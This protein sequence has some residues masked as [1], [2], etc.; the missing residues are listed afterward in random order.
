MAAVINGNR[1]FCTNCKGEFFLILPI[2]LTE[3]VSTM[4][5]FEKLHK[6]CTKHFS[7]SETKHL[8][9]KNM[10]LY[11]IYNSPTDYPDTYVARRW[12]VVPSENKPDAMDIFTIDKDLDNIR[13]KLSEMGLIRIP[14]DESDDEKIVETWL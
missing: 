1:M 7:E 9:E 2:G 10:N 13:K 5:T 4:R 12:Q 8:I 3:M 6:G 11:T 14:R